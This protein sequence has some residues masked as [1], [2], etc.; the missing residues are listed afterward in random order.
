MNP[1]RLGA[2]VVAFVKRLSATRC[3]RPPE[4]LWVYLHELHYRGAAIL[5]ITIGRLLTLAMV[6]GVR[7]ALWLALALSAGLIGEIVLT[8]IYS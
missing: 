1:R 7:G 6:R 5:W 2:D 4:G 3:W 8:Q